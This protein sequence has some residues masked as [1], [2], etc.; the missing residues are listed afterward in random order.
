MRELLVSGAHLGQDAALEAA[1]VEEQVGVVLGVH[2]HE[3]VLPL[4]GGD[5]ARQAV[6]DVPEHRAAPGR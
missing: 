6:I 4:H 5:G 1:H 2:G 3:A